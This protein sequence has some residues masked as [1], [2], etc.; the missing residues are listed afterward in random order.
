ME[1]KNIVQ[2]QHGYSSDFV[3]SVIT[4]AVYLICGVMVSKGAVLGNLSPFGASYA[5]AVPKKFLLSSL[6]GTALGYILLS[7]ND[8]FRYIAVVLAI[9]GIRWLISDIKS[10]KE[11]KLF[12]PLA[13]FLPIIATGIALTFVSTS[14][15][16][17]F[18]DCVI[19][20]V[21]AG[22]AAFFMKSAV[23]L[24]GEKRSISAYSQQETASL[25]MT[26]CILILAFGSLA[27]QNISVGRILAVIVILLCARY[28]SITGGTISGTATG[29]IFSIANRNQGFICGGYAFGG[30]MS[31]LFAPLGKLGCA[32]SFVI[33]NSVMCL[34]FGET[35]DAVSLFIES[36]VGATIFMILPKEVGNYISPV[37]STDSSASV[38]ESLR[39]NIVMRLDFASKAISGVKNDVGKVSEKLNK[40]YSPTFN[41]VCDNVENDV[42]SSCG[43]K[44]YCHDK[45]SGVTRDD[46]YRLEDRLE[47]YGE[48]DETDVEDLFVKKCCRRSEIA[49][50]MN[51]NYKQFISC[52]EAGRRASELRS[53]VAGQFSGVSDV[54]KDL[55]DEFKNT[56]KSD[57]ES[58]NRIISAVSELGIVPIDCVCLISGSGR[59]KVELELSSKG[60]DKISKGLLMRSISKCCGRSFDLPAISTAGNRTRATLSEMPQ[61]DIEIG[62]DQHIANNG[63]L[64]G[65]SIN[66]FN[67]GFGKVY[68]IIC[69]GMGTG[70]RA[71]VDGNMATAVMTR[72]IRAGLS[73]NSALKIVNSA[74]MVKSEDESLSTIDVTSLDLF[75]GKATFRKAGAP[76]T[77]IRKGGRVVSKEMPSLPVGILNGVSFS[78]DTI[79][80]TAGDMVVMVSDGVLLGDDK[81]LEN[82]IRTWKE[83]ST[84]DLAK[85][86]VSEAMK[87]RNDGHE[88]D[89]TALCVKLI[90]NE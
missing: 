56:L 12:A 43:L 34:A 17:S 88:D 30:M 5:A 63:N 13:A 66:Y 62:A 6:F 33:S 71:A 16:T 10:I 45:S 21:L 15:L 86:V 69:D 57:T 80:L 74:L 61:Y 44:V 31:G 24:A 22:A 58:A 7:P 48:I 85:A 90:D 39:K 42:C 89:I 70:G 20:A 73:P 51:E 9:G 38:G 41:W 82:L 84:Q 27:W 23:T 25:V 47:K 1:V 77:Y 72:L 81:W 60:N 14:T 54:L 40:M 2:K 67:D 53:V 29:A 8:S 18:S 4:N 75:S 35:S 64:C 3:R 37:F 36:V 68:S 28:G 79:N 49:R 83:G 59:M 76:L 50:S 26:G 65:D 11:S 19:E 32:I 55:S 78:K 87:R 46:F 52:M